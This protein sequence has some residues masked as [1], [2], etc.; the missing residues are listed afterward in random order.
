MFYLRDMV[1]GRASAQTKARQCQGKPKVKMLYFRSLLE[2]AE[3]D[4]EVTVPSPAQPVQLAMFA[5]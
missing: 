1:F 3:E 2:A 4:S 5:P